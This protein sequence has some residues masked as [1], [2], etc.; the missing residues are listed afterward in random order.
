MHGNFEREWLRRLARAYASWKKFW[1]DLL[2]KPEN[3]LTRIVFTLPK[4][5][6]ESIDE[7]ARKLEE[8]GHGD[9]V[10][11]LLA[12]KKP[13]VLLGFLY[14]AGPIGEAVYGV[15]RY[16]SSHV[17]CSNVV[18]EDFSADALTVSDAI[19]KWKAD[20]IVVFT[21]KKRGRKPALYAYS[22]VLRKPREWEAVEAIRPSL[23]GSLD[24]DDLLRGLSVFLPGTTIHVYECEPA[25]NEPDT[26]EKSLIDAVIGEVS[27]E[28]ISEDPNNGSR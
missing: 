16:A 8:A 28:C 26:C 25:E 20:K 23:E 2:P 27:H 12:E 9:F 10:R 3:P 15:Y 5:E 11:A 7:I 4:K 24:I 17:K 14:Y 18:V 21:A 19:A 22:L 1:D 13:R 6:E